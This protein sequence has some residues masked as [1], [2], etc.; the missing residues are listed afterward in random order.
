MRMHLHQDS[1][2]WFQDDVDQGQLWGLSQ[3]LPNN[4]FVS[5][6][7]RLDDYS[8]HSTLASSLCLGWIADAPDFDTARGKHLLDRYH[9]VKHLLIGGWYPLL[10]YS[11]DASQWMAM[12]FNHAD[13]GEGL[14]LAFRHAQSPYASIDCPL[15]GL[16][17]E[18]MYRVIRDN[19]GEERTI[20]G[21]E[22]MT[23][24]AIIL[25]RKRSST[26]ITY[27]RVG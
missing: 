8:F 15:R 2:C 6:L 25:P 13:L 16:Q 20:S 23:G 9:A 3:Y 4:V 24:F 19:T 17:P 18:A 10:P 27:A 11:R 21:A 14:V 7:N 22:L 5:H 12:Q 26:L 1:D